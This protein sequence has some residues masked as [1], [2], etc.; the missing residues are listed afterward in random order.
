MDGGQYPASVAMIHAVT[1][2]TLAVACD[3]RE[4]VAISAPNHT[5]GD[6]QAN[7]T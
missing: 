6:K 5:I 2:V 7:C 3:A 4:T 1:M